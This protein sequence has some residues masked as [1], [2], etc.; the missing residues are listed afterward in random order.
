MSYYTPTLAAQATDE[1]SL[2]LLGNQGSVTFDQLQSASCHVPSQRTGN[3]QHAVAKVIN[4]QTIW[5]YTDLLLHEIGPG[6]DEG[7]AEE[8]LSLSSQ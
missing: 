8:S 1:A 5:P 2:S 4:D 7:F 6:L 3:N